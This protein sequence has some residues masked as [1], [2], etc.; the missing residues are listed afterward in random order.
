M[1][2]TWLPEGVR[3]PGTHSP[4]SSTPAESVQAFLCEETTATQRR[5]IFVFQFCPT[6]MSLKFM[7]DIW[8]AYSD[9]VCGVELMIRIPHQGESIARLQ[10]L[11]A[12]ADERRP[13]RATDLCSGQCLIVFRQVKLTVDNDTFVYFSHKSGN[14]GKD[15]DEHLSCNGNHKHDKWRSSMMTETM[16][17]RSGWLWPSYTTSEFNA[18]RHTFYQN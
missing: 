18:M 6:L 9:L 11:L 8:D 2:S 5:A 1:K 10:P 15:N 17:K 14:R 12:D 7:G 3:E 4:P 16:Y 13:W